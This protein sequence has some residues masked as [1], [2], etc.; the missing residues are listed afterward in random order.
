VSTLESTEICLSDKG[1]V[2][3]TLFP[4]CTSAGFASTFVIHT[5]HYQQMH[6]Y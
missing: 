4:Q 2:Q 6:I 5:V 1:E 3:N